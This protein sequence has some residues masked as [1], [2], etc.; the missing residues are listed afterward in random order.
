M[1]HHRHFH[2]AFVATRL[3]VRLPRSRQGPR[4][5][6]EQRLRDHAY[7]AIVTPRVFADTLAHDLDAIAHDLHLWV[8]CF[9]GRRD[10]A[11]QGL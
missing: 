3:V 5:C 4:P 1:S 11:R 10:D 6:L 9:I 2:T 7:D 8:R